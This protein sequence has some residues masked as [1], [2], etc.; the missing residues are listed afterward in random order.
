MDFKTG[1]L[2]RRNFKAALKS[3]GVIVMCG[4][5]YGLIRSDQ[6]DRSVGNRLV[7]LNIQS[8]LSTG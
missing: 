7:R 2:I 1:E 6:M 4:Q 8:Q 3:F 5:F